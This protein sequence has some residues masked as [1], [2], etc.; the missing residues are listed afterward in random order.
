M[1]LV[2]ATA[3]SR[4]AMTRAFAALTGAPD[5]FAGLRFAGRT[6]RWI[7]T[8]AAAA[9]G[10]ALDEALYAAFADAYAQELRAELSGEP[11]SALPGA[12]SLLAALAPRDDVALGVATGNLRRTAQ[13]K[14]EHAALDAYLALSRGGYG[15]DHA[16]RP[17]VLRAALAACAWPASARVIVVGDSEHDVHAAHAVGAL[18]V[19]VATGSRSE[20]ELRA[21]GAVATLPDLADTPTALA[22]L[23]E[24]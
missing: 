14:L 5:A 8:S 18:A 1:T 12:A 3:A 13:L 20:A 17:D 23:L 7:V 2:R 4:A 22:T 10:V 24:A 6:D 21:A 19:G 16:E 11:S 15:D 9:A